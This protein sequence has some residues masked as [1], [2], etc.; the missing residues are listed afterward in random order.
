MYLTKKQECS[1]NSLAQADLGQGN[2]VWKREWAIT[3][4]VGPGLADTISFHGIKLLQE[5]IGLQVHA[6]ASCNDV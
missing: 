5:F 2:S 3:H 4:V 6:V 1:R